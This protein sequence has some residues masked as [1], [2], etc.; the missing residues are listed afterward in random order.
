MIAAVDKARRVWEW[1]R[2][3]SCAIRDEDALRAFEEDPDRTWLVS[4]PRTGSHM[5]RLVAEL[6]FDQPLLPRTFY[7]PLA[8]DYLLR[9]THDREL[10]VRPGRAIYLYREPV[11]TVFSEL[12]YR[13]GASWPDARLEEVAAEYGRHLARWL[14]RGDVTRDR[15]C[16]TYGEIVRGPV[17]AVGKL[18]RHFGRP[19][20]EERARRVWEKVTR[21]EVHRKTRH[22]ERVVGEKDEEYR[23]AR[24]DFR[25]ERAREVRAA[26]LEVDAALATVLDRLAADGG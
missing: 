18:C 8:E 17:E 6:Y 21:E 19:L 16:L 12:R 11:A 15:T 7:H 22:D 5:V 23:R 9:H 25:Q 24:A 13:H 10:T 1:L 4:F 26:I 3:G 14:L 20:D 2:V